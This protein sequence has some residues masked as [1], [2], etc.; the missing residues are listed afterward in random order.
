MPMLVLVGQ[1]LEQNRLA[2]VR[3]HIRMLWILHNFSS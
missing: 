3:R 1:V 2:C